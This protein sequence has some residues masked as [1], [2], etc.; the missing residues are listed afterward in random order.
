MLSISNLIAIIELFV[1]IF[2]GLYLTHWFN[3]KDT[4]TRALKD[5]Y[6]QQIQ[7]IKKDLD[8]FFDKLFEN[9]VSGKDVVC[10]YEI[11]RLKL[12][13]FDSGMLDSLPVRFEKLLD[14]VQS[15]D[16]T[17]LNINTL[18]A[19]IPQISDTDRPIRPFGAP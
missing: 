18:L 14:V 15:V 1:T 11:E 17:N 8:D 16:S 19:F 2:V 5:C 9:K 13:C 10:W 3:V 4:K 7:N 6:I 12:E